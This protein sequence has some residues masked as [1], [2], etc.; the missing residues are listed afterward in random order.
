MS[1]SMTLIKK[2]GMFVPAFEEDIKTS[3]GIKQGKAFLAEFIQQSP[4]SLEHHRLYFGGLLKFTLDYWQP[5]VTCISPTE[6]KL[7]TQYSERIEHLGGLPG[8]L[9]EP[10][11]DYIAHV[12]KG[13]AEKVVALE[14]DIAALHTW[15]KKQAGYWKWELTPTGLNQ[16]L[17]S[18][19]FN[20][21]NQERFNIFYKRAFSVIWQFVLSRDFESQDAAQDAVNQLLAMGG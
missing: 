12:N 19:N 14:P 9:A 10:L 11:A 20:N 17:D 1:F 6:V 18:I 16:K 2:G 4:R 13:R 5:S 7:L 3:Q 21:M 15:V 8:S